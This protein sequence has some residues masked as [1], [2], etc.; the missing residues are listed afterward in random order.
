MRNDETYEQPRICGA[1]V[2]Y[3]CLQMYADLYCTRY[4]QEQIRRLRVFAGIGT[5][6]D[7]MPLLF[8]NRPLVRD[9]VS[10][11]RM[12]Y[13]NGT[14]FVV[15]HMPGCDV[16]RRAFRGLNTILRM[17]A[18]SGKISKPGDIT[19]IFFGYY[20]A[21]VFNSVKRIGTD[22]Q[23]AFGVFFG[24]EVQANAAK[25]FALN[26]E[27]RAL[28]ERYLVEL[29]SADQPFAPYIYWSDAPT[30]VLGLL[31]KRMSD[32]T[33]LPAAVIRQ[34]DTIHGSGR[35]PV[36][37]P[38]V[39]RTKAVDAYAAGH[40]VAFG[41]G[42]HGDAD[43]KKLYDFLAND[44]H[45]VMSQTDMS[46]YEAKPD[47]VIAHDGTGDV[48]IDIVLFLEYLDELQQ[49]RPFGSGFP[50]P[51]VLLKFRPEDGDWTILG[52]TKQHLKIRLDHGLEVLLWN[53][54]PLMEKKDSMKE[55]YVIGHLVK[56]EFRDIQ[57]VQFV[58]D[59]DMT[60]A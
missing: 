35:S 21:P 53:Q 23:D 34:D 50:A 1:Y 20:L 3:Q 15:N 38:F 60:Y 30:G 16:Y 48:V 45:A 51:S 58:C 44:V 11:A 26:N 56:N 22:M 41:I 25:L 9:A 14:D 39:T 59:A 28:V 17:F 6:S 19:E 40:E 24:A 49:L 2:V 36:W 29:T 10:I 46:Q 57:T 4:V 54:A 18:D 33:G 55:C 12:I 8:E 5:I 42:F 13:S 52:S 7:S 27:R 32:M 37:Y 43:I 31:A 47:F